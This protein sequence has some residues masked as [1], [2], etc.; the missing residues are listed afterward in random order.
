MDLSVTVHLGSQIIG[1]CIHTTDTNTVQATGHLVGFLVE[2]TP[3]MQNGHNHFQSRFSLLFVQVCGNT[4]A[5]VN[6]GY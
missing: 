3:G 1:K 4:P 5:I 6:N 2:L